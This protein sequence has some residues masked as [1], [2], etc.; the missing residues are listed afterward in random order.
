M[1]IQAKVHATDVPIVG[2]SVP[3]DAQGARE[4]GFE[5]PD[6]Y[7]ASAI[8]FDNLA[9]GR[10]DHVAV[11]GPAGTR[12]Y[13]ELCAEACR[14]GNALLGAELTSGDRVLLFLDCW[15][16]RGTEPVRRIISIEN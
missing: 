13:A 7:N 6:I 9:R 16:P 4:I 2:D 11:T 14:F 10:A 8:L 3:R 5:L 1:T 12:T 15:F